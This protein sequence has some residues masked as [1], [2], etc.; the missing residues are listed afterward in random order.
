[1][2]KTYLVHILY[3]VV[4][5]LQQHPCY[6]FRI[7]G[8][9]RNTCIIFSNRL[10]IAHSQFFIGNAE[11]ALIPSSVFGKT[12]NVSAS[13]RVTKGGYKDGNDVLANAA[14]MYVNGK[15]SKEHESVAEVLTKLTDDKTSGE[16]GTYF[17]RRKRCF[18][19]Y[20]KRR[21]SGIY[22]H[23]HKRCVFGKFHTEIC[24]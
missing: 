6:A 14:E 3:T 13:V 11:P 8:K 21:N 24:F 10:N 12:I 17:Q 18:P 5:G 4:F 22:F 7:F 19:S 1:M 9:N 16:E 23:F 15:S 20:R 2:S